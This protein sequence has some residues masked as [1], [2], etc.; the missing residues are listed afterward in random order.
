ML[1][2]WLWIFS[3]KYPLMFRACVAQFL[4]DQGFN[5]PLEE[6][7]K[8]QKAMGFSEPSQIVNPQG[9]LAASYDDALNTRQLKRQ[10]DLISFFGRTRGGRKE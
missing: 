3:D 7:P 9:V 5:V 4:M 8:I 10:P 1:P 6:I 2:E